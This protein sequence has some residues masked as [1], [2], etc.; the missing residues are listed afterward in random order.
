MKERRK[1]EVEQDVEKFERRITKETTRSI[2][3]AEEKR[4]G[5]VYVWMRD[6]KRYETTRGSWKSVLQ[7]PTTER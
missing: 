4:K 6:G 5:Y 2:K 7:F 1:V 3:S